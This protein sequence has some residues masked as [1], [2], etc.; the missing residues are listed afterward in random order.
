EEEDIAEYL[1][2]ES[3]ERPLPY[4]LAAL[5]K[6]HS[7]GN[8]LFMLAALEHLQQRGFITN[9]AGSWTLSLPLDEI[10]LEVPESLREMNEAQVD[11]LDPEV[12]RI[13][14][15]ASINGVQFS[16]GVGAPPASVDEERFE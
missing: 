3:S 8:P 10:G 12:Q 5:L 11:S 6:R 1:V 2:G 15:V 7:E 13:L 9:S 14:E 16:G 4:G